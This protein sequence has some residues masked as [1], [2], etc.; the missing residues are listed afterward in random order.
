MG[1]FICL[2]SS[3]VKAICLIDLGAATVAGALRLPRLRAA[4]RVPVT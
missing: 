4:I 2:T 3:S 1:Q